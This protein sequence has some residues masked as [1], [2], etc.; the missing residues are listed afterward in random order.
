MSFSIRNT[1][2]W[3]HIHYIIIIIFVIV[4]IIFIIII[5][6]VIISLFTVDVKNKVKN[7][8]K[9]LIKRNSSVKNKLQ[10][11]V[12]TIYKIVAPD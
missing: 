2:N 5:I 10:Y 7:Y 11:I 12:V 8:N 9:I 4:V 1:I 6:I 3:C